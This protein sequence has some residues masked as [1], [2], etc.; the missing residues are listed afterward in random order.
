MLSGGRKP[1]S[2]TVTP[3]KLIPGVWGLRGAIPESPSGPGEG[4]ADAEASAGGHWEMAGAG[5]L[6]R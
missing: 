2:E 5:G 6:C 4:E 3:L 1:D